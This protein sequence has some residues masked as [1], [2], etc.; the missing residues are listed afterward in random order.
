MRG[1][2]TRGR[3][4]T[5]AEWADT[6]GVDRAKQVI[7]SLRGEQGWTG[8]SDTPKEASEVVWTDRWTEQQTDQ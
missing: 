4:N 7:E 6:Q 8:M 3:T 2:H 1:P 5:R